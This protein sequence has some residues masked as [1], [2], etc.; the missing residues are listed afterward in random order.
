V[1]LGPKAIAGISTARVLM[2]AADVG[3]DVSFCV[4]TKK[5]GKNDRHN[6]M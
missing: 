5:M 4:I 6:L 3:I 1:F 2:V